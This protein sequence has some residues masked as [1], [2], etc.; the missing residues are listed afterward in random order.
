MPETWFSPKLCLIKE[1]YP[2]KLIL[3]FIQSVQRM[4]KKKLFQRSWRWPLVPKPRN[5]I[6]RR[7]LDFKG[8]IQHNYPLTL[9]NL[10]HKIEKDM[11]IIFHDIRTSVTRFTQF[12]CESLLG[13]TNPN[14]GLFVFQIAKICILNRWNRLKTTL[15][16]WVGFFSIIW[17]V[18]WG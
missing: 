11:V 13:L 5:L 14:R 9:N 3:L 7:S 8:A 17:I 12:P 4:A 18:K 10:L 15:E 1:L 16:V 6:R 2:W